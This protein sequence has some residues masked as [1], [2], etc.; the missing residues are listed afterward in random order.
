MW[1]DIREVTEATM[2]PSLFQRHH[3]SSEIDWEM[4]ACRW[5]LLYQSSS[6]KAIQYTVCSLYIGD[7]CMYTH[8]FS[9]V[10]THCISIWTL[11]ML[12]T[13]AGNVGDGCYVSLSHT[14]SLSLSHTQPFKFLLPFKNA[15]ED[16][17]K[18]KIQQR[19]ILLCGT[20]CT[21]I[22]HCWQFNRSMELWK[23]MPYPI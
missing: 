8:I 4:K 13:P 11:F 2:T 20:I 14:L 16:K 17:K 7:L 15:A 5:R 1:H 10:H 19:C 18:K 9:L 3:K 6:V 22:I 23:L 21:H 12:N